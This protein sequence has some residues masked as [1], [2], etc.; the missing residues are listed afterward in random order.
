M[1]TILD[2]TI[3][4]LSMDGG[5]GIF[6]AVFVGTK[7]NIRMDYGNFASLVAEIDSNL[8]ESLA[9]KGVEGL[10]SYQGKFYL[11][12]EAVY[13]YQSGIQKP[14]GQNRYTP[15]YYGVMFM[16][17]LSRLY[18]PN[19]FPDVINLVASYPLD[20]RSH[21]KTLSA[22]FEGK[23][24]WTTPRGKYRVTVNECATWPES[25]GAV[26]NFSESVNGKPNPFLTHTPKT[27]RK[28][29]VFI[30]IGQETSQIGLLGEGG[31]VIVGKHISIY[32][33]GVRTVL[34][35]I[36]NSFMA[37]PKHTALIKGVVGGLRDSDLIT[38]LN[39]RWFY[40]AGEDMN[41]KDIVESA[42]TKLTNKIDTAYTN[43]TGGRVQY[44]IRA[45][46]GIVVLGKVLDAM[47]ESKIKNAHDHM[48]NVLPD[49]EIM[50]GTAKG[51]AL[52]VMI[53]WDV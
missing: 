44:V 15:T 14:R 30:D 43:I 12:G 32:N 28:I 13:E 20:D 16:S 50:Y 24:A 40:N 31:E 51:N 25:S 41:C 29:G 21:R 34:D 5:H 10:L 27:P 18:P 53:A 23:W 47:F 3:E 17:M 45:G 4:T 42:T 38:I 52:G 8:Y 22:L 49:N 33:L 9:E 35:D 1:A 2:P 19:N 37:S 48:K 39:E 36:R 46:G 6:K 7:R 11:T 26:T